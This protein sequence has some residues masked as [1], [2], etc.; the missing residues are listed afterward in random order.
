[1]SVT[2]QLLPPSMSSRA[3]QLARLEQGL[4]IDVVAD[5]PLRIKVNDVCGNACHFCHNEG[6]A[7]AGSG[8]G[9]NA[10]RRSVYIRADG[11]SGASDKAR[12]LVP[13]IVRPD[14]E[15]ARTITW[16]RDHCRTTEAHLTGDEPTL[17]P[18]LPALVEMTAQTYNVVKM[19]SNGERGSIGWAELGRAG[20]SSVNFSIYG[21]SIEHFLQTQT[22]GF[23]AAMAEHRI[24]A[25]QEAMATSLAA[26]T[27]MS[28]TVWRMADRSA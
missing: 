5:R 15:Y 13:A 9:I 19:T 11:P 21:L 18:E 12:T 28:H 25:V 23:P 22:P 4:P 16:L 7:V 2:V 27:S 20:L 17:H 10:L 26:L 14:A 1:M 24:A 6:T 3:G 8:R